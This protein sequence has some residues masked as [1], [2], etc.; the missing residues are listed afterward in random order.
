MADTKPVLVVTEPLAT[1]DMVITHLNRHGVPVARFNPADLPTGELTISARFGDRPASTSVAGQ[2]RTPS[3]TAD[4]EHVR[5][6][7]W[8]RP[9]WPAFEHLDVDDAAL[10]RRAGPPRNRGRPPRPR[11]P[12]MGQPP[13]PQ[14]GGRP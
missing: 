9:V 3:R 10:C 14:R 4:L 11:R 12:A 6:V 5:A 13:R 1:A 8:R 2:L 7:Y